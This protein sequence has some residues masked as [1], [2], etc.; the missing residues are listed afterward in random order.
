MFPSVTVTFEQRLEAFKGVRTL[1]L[2]GAG[3]EALKQQGA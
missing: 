3:A 2:S 1:D